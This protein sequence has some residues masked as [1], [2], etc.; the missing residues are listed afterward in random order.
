MVDKLMM[1]FSA[2][3]DP[4]LTSESRAMTTETRPTAR[5]GTWYVGLTCAKKSE[6]VSPL[7]RANAHVSLET[8]ASV[9]KLAAHAMKIMAVYIAVA[10]GT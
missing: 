9:P 3:D 7:S 4:I 5:N 6:N 1:A 10:L 8:D 2:T